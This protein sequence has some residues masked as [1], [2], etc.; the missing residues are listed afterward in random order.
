V[1][2]RIYATARAAAQ[3]G[4]PIAHDLKPFADLFVQTLDV[5]LT[6]SFSTTLVDEAAS[7]YKD[8]LLRQMEQK[9]DMFGKPA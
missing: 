2:S 1:R 9:L 6:C 3:A 5:G 4:R 7:R 8:G